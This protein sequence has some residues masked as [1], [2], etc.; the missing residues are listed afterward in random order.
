MLLLCFIF[1]FFGFIPDLDLRCTTRDEVID[2]IEKIIKK[3]PHA[4]FNKL[5]KQKGKILP[6]ERPPSGQGGTHLQWIY[7]FHWNR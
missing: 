1:L 4:N 5:T 2:T 3:Y 6:I 7:S